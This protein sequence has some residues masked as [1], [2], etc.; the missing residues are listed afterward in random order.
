MASPGYGDNG[1]VIG[2]AN[3]PTTSAASGV[4]SLGELAEAE[5][6]GIWPAPKT[7][8]EFIAKV[9]PMNGTTNAVSFTS[10]P[11]TY[12]NLRIVMS[13]ARRD[14]SSN[15]GISIQYNSDVTA[16][17]YGWQVMYALGG[18][19]SAQKAA[20]FPPYGD[21]PNSQNSGYC[22]WDIGQYSDSSVGT[23]C[24]WQ[25]GTDVRNNGATLAGAN[26]YEVASAVTQI[27]VVSSYTT[28]GYYFEAPTTFALF[29]IGSA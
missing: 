10:I 7:T 5:R 26:G 19:T 24:Q 15:A 12:R 8:M 16:A 13:N 25:A 29:G 21:M 23:T 18:A 17:N 3:T 4:W 11:Q 2:P 14:N 27:D 9:G 1:S 6:D 20:Y 22:I 28:S